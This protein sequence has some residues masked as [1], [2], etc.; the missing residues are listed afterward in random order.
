MEARIM[1]ILHIVKKT[2]DASTKKIIDLHAASNQVTTIDLTK[3][4]VSYDKLVADIFAHDKVF[5]W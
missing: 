5:C 2:P 1:K 3:S 4:G